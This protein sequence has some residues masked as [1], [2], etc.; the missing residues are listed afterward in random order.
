M[1]LRTVVQL[2]SP[3]ESF[4]AVS[5][6]REGSLL[7]VSVECPDAHKRFRLCCELH[8]AHR[9]CENVLSRCDWSC[10]SAPA[11]GLERVPTEAVVGR[12]WAADVH[13]ARSAQDELSRTLA[14][15]ESVG[16]CSVPDASDLPSATE[17]A[18]IASSTLRPP[19]VAPAPA[20][21]VL[22]SNFQS[23]GCVGSLEP[24][25]TEAVGGKQWADEVHA[26]CAAQESLGQTLGTTATPHMSTNDTATTPLSPSAKVAAS[27][28]VGNLERAPTEAVVGKQWADEVHAARAAQEALRC[29][30]PGA[31]ASAEDILLTA[32]SLAATS[33][34]PGA[35]SSPPPLD[36][37][38]TE[39]AVG[40]QWAEE[41]QAARTAHAALESHFAT[42]GSPPGMVSAACSFH[43]K[44]FFSK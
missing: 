15:S 29:S 9:M 27:F 11:L 33:L 35:E 36:R 42:K 22:E 44:V 12:A 18:P 2:G 4:P 26:V 8:T 30:F 21:G 28:A 39:A 6:I 14:A 41:A 17:T 10:R 25:P 13:A 23:A 24:V 31:V 43:A 40:G 38:P 16:S 20:A 7:Q 19:T 3:G 32:N 5:V 1:D 37:V 34:S